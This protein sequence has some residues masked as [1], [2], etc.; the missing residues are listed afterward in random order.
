[1]SITRSSHILLFTLL[2]ILLILGTDA[3]P[4]W[5][6]RQAALFIFGDSLFDAGTNNFI[7]TTTALQAN[8]FPYGES[9]FKYPTGRFCDGRLITDFIAKSAGLPLIPPYL[10]PKF[11]FIGGANFA[12]G[13]A[14]ALVE[15][16]EGFVA[17]LKTQMMQFEKL[18][19]KLKSKFG[20]EEA[21]KIVS[22]AVYM[23]SIGG[24]DYYFPISSNS[25]LFQSHSHE[26]YV[27]MVIG[28]LTTVVKKINSKG[29][30]N[31]GFVNLGPLGC[32]PLTRAL[33]GTSG[34]CLSELNE[35]AKLHNRAL[36]KAL[37]KLANE[38]DGFKY[39]IFDFFNAGIQRINN[40][41]EFGFKEGKKACCGSGLYRGNF[42]CGG[43]RGEA[44]YELCRDPSEYVFFDSIH[45]SERTYR[46]LAG[47]MWNGSSPTAGPYNLRSLFKLAQE[48]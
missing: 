1:M 37:D 13:G 30:Q 25:T 41:S 24:N 10:H 42:S 15:T 40:A 26:E 20:D 39:S 7:N 34:A 45:P 19:K 43:K 4:S 11:R 27:E 36:P 12:S 31:F 18:E 16:N 23:I 9:F 46:Q 47:L 5:P 38:L 2:S 44:E 28:N 3:Q 35:L 32:F 33:A 21:G 22:K 6:E 48:K 17:T 29:G 8:F 14:G